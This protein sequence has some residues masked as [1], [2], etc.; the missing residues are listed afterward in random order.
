M[1]HPLADPSKPA[2]SGD[3]ALAL[4][5]EDMKARVARSELTEA[6]A[7]DL[8]GAALDHFPAEAHADLRG[9]VGRRED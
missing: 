4:V 1:T 9:L 2:S 7:R 3:L 5:F 8:L 6:D